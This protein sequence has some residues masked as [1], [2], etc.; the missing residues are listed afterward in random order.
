VLVALCFVVFW[1]T[2]FPLI[3]EAV[4]GGEASV[5]PPWFN[6]YITPLALVLVL[7]MSGIG[8]LIAWRRATAANLRRNFAL[9]VGAALLV[10]AGMVA[11]GETRSFGALLMFAF[12]A[13]VLC[14]VGQEL[15][16]GVRARR[17]MSRDSVPAA[18]V[19]VVRRNRRRYGGYTVHAG[20][21]V[22]FV[23]I[24]AS[25]AF[26]D[27]RLVELRAGQ[28]E[29]IDGYAITYERPTSELVVAGNGRLGGSIS[30]R[31][32]GSATAT[33]P[34]ERCRRSSRTSPRRIRAS[35]RSRASSRARRP[36]R[37]R[38]APACAR[39][40][41]RPSRPTSAGCAR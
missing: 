4:T 33:A 17:A 37:S 5:G 7:L 22:L 11:A 39:T 14:A 15:W 8:P 32:C 13:F 40:S 2:F 28:T 3:S 1:G 12:A 10:L 35:A 6:R 29:R 30:E 36:P 27:Q 23:G 38:C 34:S 21:A 31:G 26:Q 25:S 9:P 18:V 24:A 16:R 19:A 41:G 20:I